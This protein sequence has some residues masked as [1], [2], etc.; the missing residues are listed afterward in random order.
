M[1]RTV[2][3]RHD[4]TTDRE[5]TKHFYTGTGALHKVKK[6]K[7]F[8]AQAPDGSGGAAPGG[9]RIT[10]PKD[11]KDKAGDSAGSS[12]VKDE[13]EAVEPDKYTSRLLKY[14]PAEVIALYLTLDIIIR[15]TEPAPLGLY[16]FVFLFGIP[17]TFFYLR[18]IEKVHKNSQIIISVIAYCVWVFAI[19]GPFVFVNWYQPLYGAIILPMYTFIV[20]IIEA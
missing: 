13:V 18:R 9:Y 3:S 8:F 16:W 12:K 10:E 5:K 20:P 7:P 4:L 11:Y 17:A 1:V 14:I 6:D 15:S 2:V 19:G